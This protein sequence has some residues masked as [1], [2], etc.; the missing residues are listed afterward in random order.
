MKNLPLIIR[1]DILRETPLIVGKWK[2]HKVIFI[3]I[4][5]RYNK[6]KLPSLK[7]IG[8]NIREIEF[9][10]CSGIKLQV[11]QNILRFFPKVEKL[12]FHTSRFRNRYKESDK[13]NI[14]ELKYLKELVIK[15]NCLRVSYA[16]N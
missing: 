14:L 10:H 8:R 11:L 7:S 4:N 16:Q 2:F 6:A 9:V 13:N 15:Q 1:A 12:T 3:S 5:K